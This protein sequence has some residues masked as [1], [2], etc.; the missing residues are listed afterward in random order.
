MVDSIGRSGFGHSPKVGKKRLNFLQ[1]TIRKME[2]WRDKA[3][4]NIFQQRERYKRKVEQNQAMMRAKKAGRLPN[5]NPSSKLHELGFKPKAIHRYGLTHSTVPR[6]PKYSIVE[7]KERIY[8]NR[9]KMF[10]KGKKK[11]IPKRKSKRRKVE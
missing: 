8:G 11:V 10:D 1:Q 4:L 6:K 2:L 3:R 9:W 7:P 5:L